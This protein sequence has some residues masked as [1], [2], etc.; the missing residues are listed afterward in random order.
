MLFE[1]W[2]TGSRNRVGAFTSLE[3]ALTL[4]L[5]SVEKHGAH[6]ADT[7]MLAREDEAGDTELLAEGAELIAMAE[8]AQ[9]V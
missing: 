9:T 3:A 2:D 4:V 5:R 7:L 8:L 6:Y 1:I